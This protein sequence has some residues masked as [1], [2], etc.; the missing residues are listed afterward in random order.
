MID[1]LPQQKSLPYS[2]ES[3][4]AVLGGILLDPSVLPTVS[5]RLKPARSS[6]DRPREPFQSIWLFSGR[7][8]G[9]FFA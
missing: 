9:R 7:A 2:E 8:A 1:V 3:E 6:Y 4:R 5:G